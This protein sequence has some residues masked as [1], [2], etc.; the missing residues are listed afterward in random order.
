M[1]TSRRLRLRFREGMTLMWPTRKSKKR[2][3]DNCDGHLLL[4]GVVISRITGHLQS[5]CI[6]KTFR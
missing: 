1:G 6:S 2:N 3:S 4:V 5:T